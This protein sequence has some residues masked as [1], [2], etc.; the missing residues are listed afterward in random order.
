METSTATRSAGARIG[1]GAAPAML[2]VAV[3]A[4]CWVITAKRMQGMDMGPGTE[5]GGVGWFAV[6]WA[7]MMA[8]MMRPSLT[9]MGQA[10][11]RRS[12]AAGAACPT[13]ASIVVAAVY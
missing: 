13:G 10:Y 12:R 7:T 8:A 3:A 11:S 6:V 9:P 1:R 4:I 2:L 5:L